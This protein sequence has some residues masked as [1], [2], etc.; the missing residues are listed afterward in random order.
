MSA[1]DI[2]YPSGWKEP[3]NCIRPEEDDDVVERGISAKGQAAWQGKGVTQE[4]VISKD[5]YLSA[6]A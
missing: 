2:M 4:T 3:K 1:P 6:R 5:R